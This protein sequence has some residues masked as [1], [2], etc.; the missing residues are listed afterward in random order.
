[1]S[2]DV[3]EQ[4]LPYN[5]AMEPLLNYCIFYNLKFSCTLRTCTLFIL[6]ISQ[7]DQT[8]YYIMRRHGRA[9]CVGMV[10]VVCIP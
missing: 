1:M 4:I 9:V 7:S 8:F 6:H 5:S 2:N 3:T 10:V